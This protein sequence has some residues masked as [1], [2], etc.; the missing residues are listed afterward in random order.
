MNIAIKTF[1]RGLR[2][3][4]GPFMLLSERVNRPR[5]VVRTAQAQQAVADQCQRLALYQYATC[6][7]CIK[8]RQHMA[9]LSLP[10]ERRDAQHN[11]THRK[12]LLALGGVAKVP[13]LRIENADGRVVWL[14]ESAAILAQ[15]DRQFA[16]A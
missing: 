9:R 16:S 4:L 6:P 5:G 1:F 8:V 10:I 7:F 2:M 11:A 14:Y 13:C 3:V 15:L 12:D